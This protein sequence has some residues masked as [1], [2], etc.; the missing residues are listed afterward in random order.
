MGKNISIGALMKTVQAFG[1]GK[2]ILIIVPFTHRSIMK[3]LLKILVTPI[4]EM[5]VNID[6]RKLYATTAHI[7]HNRHRRVL[8]ELIYK[9]ITILNKET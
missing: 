2:L 3:E 1:P 8:T 4:L 7:R 6:M 5:V 9:E